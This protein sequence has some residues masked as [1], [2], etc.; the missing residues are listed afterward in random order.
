[1]SLSQCCKKLCKE[2]LRKIKAM[3]GDI[4]E[5]KNSCG[6]GDIDLTKGIMEKNRNVSQPMLQKAMQGDIAG[7]NYF[8]K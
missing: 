8:F 1:M 6:S 3:Q 7:N 5:N 4:A 2:T